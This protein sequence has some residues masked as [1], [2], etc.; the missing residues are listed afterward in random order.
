MP[1]NRQHHREH[2]KE[3]VPDDY[4]ERV[5]QKAY[6]LYLARGGVDGRDLDDWLQAERIVKEELGLED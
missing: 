2:E 4:I 1:K 5:R 3:I 6:E